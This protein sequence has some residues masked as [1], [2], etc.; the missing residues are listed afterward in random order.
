VT[1]AATAPALPVDALA[2][3][4]PLTLELAA[5]AALSPLQAAPLITPIRHKTATVP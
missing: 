1:P 5:P 4:G 3:A 2:V